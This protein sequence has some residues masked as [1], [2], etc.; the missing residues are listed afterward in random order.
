MERKVLNKM[1]FLTIFV[2]EFFSFIFS[3]R[4]FTGFLQIFIF[5]YIFYMFP[6]KRDEVPK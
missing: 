5:F 1:D 2:I 6:T 3:V 4:V